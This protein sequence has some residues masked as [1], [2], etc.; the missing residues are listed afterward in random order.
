MAKT[1]FGYMKCPTPKCG[2]RVVVKENE[3]GTLSWS[4]DECDGSGYVKK[5]EA[6]YPAWAASIE[7][8]SAPA[9]AADPKS[10][11]APAPKEKP[12]AP[13][14]PASSLLG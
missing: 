13:A 2:H 12:A 5:G 8:A 1:K 6:G 10:A 14:K 3:R 4:C 9:P 11:P 7:R